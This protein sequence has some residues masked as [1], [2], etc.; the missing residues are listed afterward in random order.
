MQSISLNDAKKIKHDILRF[1]LPKGWLATINIVPLICFWEHSK[2]QVRLVQVFEEER[3]FSDGVHFLI[4]KEDG[5][6]KCMTGWWIGTRFKK[7][8]DL[9]W[10]KGRGWRE[11]IAEKVTEKVFDIMTFLLPF[12]KDEKA[13]SE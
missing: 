5:S 4:Y 3:K 9:F 6:Y 8:E 12:D 2:R 7:K 13:E 1:T 10:D 11:R